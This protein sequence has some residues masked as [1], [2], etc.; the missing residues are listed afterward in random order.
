[1]NYIKTFNKITLDDYYDYNNKV[2]EKKKS[3]H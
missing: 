3:K 1:M 2:V